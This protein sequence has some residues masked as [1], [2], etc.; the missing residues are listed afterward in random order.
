MLLIDSKWEH[1]P[2]RAEGEWYEMSR[3]GKG[4]D[5]IIIDGGSEGGW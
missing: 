4:G 2:E 3:L 1:K 5:T